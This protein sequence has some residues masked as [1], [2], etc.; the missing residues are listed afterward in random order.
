MRL[1]AVQLQVVLLSVALVALRAAVALLRRDF[2]DSHVLGQ[3]AVL[4]KASAAH[5]A[6]ERLLAGVD[7]EVVEQ[8]PR[9]GELLA[10]ALERAL[11]RSLFPTNSQR[12]LT[13]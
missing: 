4:R 8:V 3:V 2:V 12:R 7:S 11:E 13:C 10:A 5:L 6:G 9:L 1:L